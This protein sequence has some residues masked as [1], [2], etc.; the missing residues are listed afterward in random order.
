MNL[1]NTKTILMKLNYILF[2]A[3][4]FIYVGCTSPTPLE[5]S[6]TNPQKI[7]STKRFQKILFVALLK[8][9]YTR[10]VAEDKLV[11]LVRPRGFA[12]YNYLPALTA[13][14]ADISLVSDR[15]KQDGFDGIVIMRLLNINKDGMKTS[16][17]PPPYYN[18]WY[19]YYSTTFPLYNV[20]GG[21]S[22]NDILNIETNIYSLTENK[23]IWT[24]VTTAV[25]ISDKN[26]MIDGVIAMVKQKMKDQGLIK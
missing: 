22:S 3:V 17:N 25:N 26:K 21:L 10:K 14:N 23:L 24:G 4:A 6:W 16:G 8:D 5:Q 7:D 9:A 13:N 18:T 12:S 15:L 11:D 1:S 19:G 20:P 2:A